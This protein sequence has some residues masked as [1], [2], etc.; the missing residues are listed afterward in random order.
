MDP[1]SPTGARR[2]GNSD[3]GRTERGVSCMRND[4]DVGQRA[5][6]GAVARGAD[7]GTNQSVNGEGE[8]DLSRLTAVLAAV[9]DLLDELDKRR[10]A[11]PA[12]S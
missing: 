5:T 6:D 10:R 7:P 9:H 1:Q 11:K 4:I 8:P 2:R 12:K 3:R